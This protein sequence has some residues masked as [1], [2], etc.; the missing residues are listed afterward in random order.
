MVNN[1]FEISLLHDHKSTSRSTYGQRPVI[2]MLHAI[3][4]KCGQ[5]FRGKFKM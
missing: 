1:Y 2:V 4:P 3:G 5:I